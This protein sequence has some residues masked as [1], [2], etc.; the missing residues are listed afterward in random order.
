MIVNGLQD[1]WC[2]L[3]GES[4]GEG[5]IWL[6]KRRGLSRQDLNLGDVI[7]RGVGLG[8]TC[9]NN[10][11]YVNLYLSLK[12]TGMQHEKMQALTELHSKT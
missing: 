12:K 2:S 3:L 7:W 1:V 4:H 10:D 8:E 9:C 5:I 6:W 11:K